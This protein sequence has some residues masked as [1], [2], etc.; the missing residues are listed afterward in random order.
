MICCDASDFA[1]IRNVVSGARCDDGEKSCIGCHGFDVITTVLFAILL[2]MA[3]IRSVYGALW[4]LTAPK[5]RAHDE[6]CVCA[7]GA[8]CG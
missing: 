4:L 2:R 5:T 7:C 1:I 8:M 6:V 3:K